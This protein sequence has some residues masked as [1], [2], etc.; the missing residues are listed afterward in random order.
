KRGSLARYVF[1]YA[2]F[3]LWASV[4]TPLQMLRRRYAMIDINS[5]PDFLV[6]AP[7]LAKWM[8]AK[9]VLDLHEVTPEFY[10]S[11]YRVSENSKTVRLMKY[12]EQIS[13]RFADHV[14]TINEP[15]EDL[16]AARGLPRAKSTVV[17]NAVDEK[18][19]PHILPSPATP[20]ST[21][22]DRF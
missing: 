15:I 8:G 9:L 6:F 2:A 13:I 21:D 4:R 16:L 12:L 19:F 7:F 1:E 11:K 22:Q 5:L 14:I 18:R 10:I 20:D 3:F 17:M